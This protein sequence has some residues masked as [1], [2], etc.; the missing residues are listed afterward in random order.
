MMMPLGMFPSESFLLPENVLWVFVAGNFEKAH[1][2]FLQRLEHLTDTL[3]LTDEL[4]FFIN[5]L[6]HFL[7][8]PANLTV[9]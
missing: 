4:S 1:G 8:F 9:V 3:L 6:F 5:N 7:F 2:P